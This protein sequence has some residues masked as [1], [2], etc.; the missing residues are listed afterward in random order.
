MKHKKV[1]T[2]SDVTTLSPII[3]TQKF[4]ES[5]RKHIFLKEYLMKI[6]ILA[7]TPLLDHELLARNCLFTD[8]LACILF[9][10]KTKEMVVKKIPA[11]LGLYPL[12]TKLYISWEDHLHLHSMS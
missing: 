12:P 7:T 9:H 3:R 1:K 10:P 5:S 2:R 11:N 4:R 8:G 6:S